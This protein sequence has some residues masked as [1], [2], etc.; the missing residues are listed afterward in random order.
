MF[1]ASCNACC[2]AKDGDAE[3]KAKVLAQSPFSEEDV[4]VAAI[5][6]EVVEEPPPKD[7]EQEEN[8]E[9]AKVET[10]CAVDAERSPSEFRVSMERSGE[11]SIGTYI[12]IT[13]NTTML[14]V[15]ILQGGAIQIW[16]DAHLDQPQL[17]V[18]DRIVEA[19]GVR[20][21]AEKLLSEL[22]QS[23][24]W[25]L[26]VQ[27]PVEFHAIIERAGSHALG[28]DLR[29]APNGSSLMISEVDE[30]PIKDWNAISKT[31]QVKK[32]DRIIEVN[33]T[34]GTSQ[35][36]LSAGIGVDRFDMVILHWE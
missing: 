25:D 11:A 32:Y 31:W 9:S 15:G 27:R 10:N 36:L 35:Q 1:G 22:K 6:P 18:H 20:G 26:R 21:D 23:T 29:Y 16:N 12:D 4:G 2:T 33:G 34:R 14:I 8:N 24:N 28:M 19:N 5:A 17:K 3:P 30:G 13:D 7:I